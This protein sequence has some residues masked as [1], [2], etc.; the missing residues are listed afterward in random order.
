M[1]IYTFSFFFNSVEKNLL[2][3]VAKMAS[4]VHETD[5]AY[6]TTVLVVVAVVICNEQSRIVINFDNHN[7]NKPLS[8]HCS[9]SRPRDVIDKQLR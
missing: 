4:T 6:V 8:N 2:T 1:D 9:N 7:Q 5:N 3:A